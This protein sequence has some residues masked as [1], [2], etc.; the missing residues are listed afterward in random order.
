MSRRM[1]P[2]PREFSTLIKEI[3]ALIDR[4]WK[5]ADKYFQVSI[6]YDGVFLRHKIAIS[7][8]FASLGLQLKVLAE[9]SSFRGERTRRSGK[10]MTFLCTKIDKQNYEYTQSRRDLPAP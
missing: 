6:K 7:Q 1:S 4:R 8:H 10:T 3:H 5:A 2:P 9:S